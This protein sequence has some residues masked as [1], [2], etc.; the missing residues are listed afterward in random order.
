[1]AAIAHCDTHI[2]LWLYAGEIIRLSKKAADAVE[3]F[4]LMIS[5]MVRMEMQFLNEIGRIKEKPQRILRVLM[6]DFGIRVCNDPFEPVVEAA[7]A[8]RW[9]RDP[10]DRIIV[11]QATLERA[12]LIT[13]DDELRKHYKPCIW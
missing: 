10:F 2:V 13:K 9:T 6:S 5:P 7:E 12:P 1:M 11:A 8:V 3:T 4:N